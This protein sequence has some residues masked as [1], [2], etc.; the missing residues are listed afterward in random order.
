[1]NSVLDD[2]NLMRVAADDFT[3]TYARVEKDVRRLR[4]LFN[5]MDTCRCGGE[6][7]RTWEI[8]KLINELKTIERYFM[9]ACR[10]K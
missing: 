6:F 7:P 2:G 9:K 3:E 4:H 10:T 5:L 8:N 1:M